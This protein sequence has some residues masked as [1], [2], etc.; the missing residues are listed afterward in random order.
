MNLLAQ[1]FT[2]P[3]V[4]GSQTFWLLIPVSM[5]VAIVYKTIRTESIRS[6]PLEAA[7]LAVY[8]IAGEACLLL[9]GWAFLSWRF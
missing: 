7:K 1:L 4:M 2:T 5:A 8:I 3:M 9:A 6:L